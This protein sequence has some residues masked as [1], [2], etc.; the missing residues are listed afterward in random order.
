MNRITDANNLWDAGTKAMS[1][2]KFK[3]RTQMYE[4]N[5][6]LET[7]MLQKELK[8]NTYV[9]QKG[10][11]FP[12]S[13]R[14]KLRYITSNAIQDKVINHVLCDEIITPAIKPYLI[15]DNGASQKGKGVSF[16][17]KRLEY[18]LRKYFLTTGSNEGY[19]LQFDFSGYYAN[20][21][22]STCKGMLAEKIKKSEAVEER[23]LATHLIDLIFQ[24][25]EMDV[26]YLSDNEIAKLYKHK[27]DPQMNMNAPPE[28]LTGEKMLK[29]GVDIG[30]QLS[31][32]IGIVYPYRIDNYVKIVRGCK[33]Y[34]RY[35][36]DGYIIHQNKEFLK[37][38]F[39]GISEIAKRYGILI[40]QKKTRIG[41]LSSGFRF[42][43][44]KYRLTDT[45]KIVKNINPKNITRE[46]RKLKA[47]KRKLAS[48]ELDYPTIE[49]SFRSWLGG[50]WKIM[51]RLQIRNINELYLELFG[52]KIKY[53]K[54]KRLNW[55]INHA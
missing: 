29:K 27:V 43:Q 15:Y 11:K 28:R 44:V 1:G 37:D 52:V 10:E 30:N 51:S 7:A 54:N 17:R 39:A 47:Y 8:E 26:S 45:G 20:I 19:I 5:Q 6:L 4:M 34:G 42:L 23:E 12:I 40:N 48:G 13:E 31:Q 53:K 24:S 3:Y 38:V 41:K 32:D 46:R 33:L 9:P 2:S 14:G 22:H 50:H 16:S 18:H 25:F 21:L 49:N 36:D 35:T 55:L